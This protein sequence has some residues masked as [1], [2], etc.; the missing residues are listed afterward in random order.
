[1][2]CHFSEYEKLVGLKSLLQEQLKPLSTVI[3]HRG[4]CC[5]FIS[6]LDAERASNAYQL[7]AVLALAEGSVTRP[8]RDSPESIRK[9]K[10]LAESVL[11]VPVTLTPGYVSLIYID[12]GISKQQQLVFAN[13]AI[14]LKVQETLEDEMSQLDSVRCSASDLIDHA[15]VERLSQEDVRQLREL[16]IHCRATIEIFNR[17]KKM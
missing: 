7:Q 8:M 14:L 17:L 1:M 4:N 9:T 5:T 13:R 3:W 12:P 11:S 10:S 2:A 15:S 16:V 6:K